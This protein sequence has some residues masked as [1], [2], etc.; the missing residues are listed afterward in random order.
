MIV[1][2][3]FGSCRGSAVTG[4]IVS[5]LCWHLWPSPSWEFVSLYGEHGGDGE[6]AGDAEPGVGFWIGEF[7][8]R[9]VAVGCGGGEHCVG[10]GVYDE[11]EC[12]ECGMDVGVEARARARARAVVLLSP[13]GWHWPHVQR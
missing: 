7:P 2:G 12:G 8:G 4:L 11:G 10:V 5:H 6:G 9:A 13:G 1:V 3:S